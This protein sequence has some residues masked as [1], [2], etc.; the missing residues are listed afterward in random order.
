MSKQ[1]GELR[2]NRSRKEADELAAEYEASGLTQ[3]AFSKLKGIA[4]KTLSRYVVRH[5]RGLR[6]TGGVGRLV[7]VKVKEQAKSGAEL[8]LVLTAGQR[9]EVRP[10]FDG[11][12]LQRLLAV[13]ERS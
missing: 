10:G 3:Q 7:A 4:L 6:T 1:A 13:V 9:I 5:R 8:T 12:T 11:E 2:R